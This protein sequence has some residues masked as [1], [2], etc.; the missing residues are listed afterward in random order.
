LK[1]DSRVDR[2]LLGVRVGETTIT[3]NGI[4]VTTRS[5]SFVANGFCHAADRGKFLGCI[6]R[7]VQILQETARFI[8]KA[9]LIHGSIASI[10]I[11]DVGVATSS[12]NWVSKTCPILTEVG[13]RSFFGAGFASEWSKP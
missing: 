12:V 9:W 6:R 1:S 8:L 11:V 10:V 4:G 13:H 3:A 2:N 7:A 5:I